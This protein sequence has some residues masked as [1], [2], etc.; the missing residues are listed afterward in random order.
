MIG[1][2]VEKYY[3]DPRRC[4]LSLLERKERD[5]QKQKRLTVS[6]LAALYRRLD[7]NGDGELDENEFS[8][9]TRKLKMDGD[10]QFLSET[11][12]KLDAQGTGKLSLTQFAQAYNILYD[13]DPDADHMDTDNVSHLLACR[14]GLDKHDKRFVFEIYSGPIT[15]IQRKTCYF[16]DGSCMVYD[17]DRSWKGRPPPSRVSTHS[18]DYEVHIFDL[19]YIVSLVDADDKWNKS[20]DS[21]IMWW[22]D[23][24]S[25]N[26]SFGLLI[27]AF[28]LPRSVVKMYRNEVLDERRDNRLVIADKTSSEGDEHGFHHLCS[29]SLS[30]QSLYIEKTPIVNPHPNFIHRFCGIFRDSFIWCSDK[31]AFLYSLDHVDDHAYEH[32]IQAAERIAR[33]TSGELGLPITSNRPP[34]IEGDFLL[35][36]SDMDQRVPRLDHNTLSLHLINRGINSKVLLS[37]HR[38][39]REESIND[40]AAANW[41]SAEVSESGIIGRLCAGV[42]R[43]LRKV[44]T[45]GGVTDTGG[46]LADGSAALLIMLI[47]NVHSHAMGSLS[48]IDN[49]I[50]K[51][52][53]DIEMCAVTKHATHIKDLR[54]KLVTIQKYVN[55]IHDIFLEMIN[56]DSSL[57]VKSD[58]H[59]VRALTLLKQVCLGNDKSGIKGTKYWMERLSFYVEKLDSVEKIYT[60]KLNEQRN[61]FTFVLS[62]FTIVTWPFGAVSAYYGMSFKNQYEFGAYGDYNDLENMY[63]QPLW[64]FQRFRGVQFFWFVIGI[65]YLLV[66]LACLHFRIFYTAT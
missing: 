63:Q 26:N 3:A 47:E 25:T 40:A 55:P 1:D 34:G 35:A 48:D 44:I 43:K 52:Q 57:A 39:E 60:G 16:E 42:R 61:S 56:P 29:L 5:Q 30:V 41:S 19:D 20:T 32:S 24:C 17:L 38:M 8:S 36:T 53:M 15:N 10:P 13:H 51:L 21:N 14:Y 9:I 4:K 23:V 65:V 27:K 12:R 59:V 2:P 7:V 46:E 49:W 22:I 37:F 18:V 28:E 62:I 11:F 33:S 31:I 6:Q 45:G 64:L 54:E 66:F 50:L 58:P